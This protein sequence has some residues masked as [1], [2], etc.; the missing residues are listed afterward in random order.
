MNRALSFFKRWEFVLFILLAVELLGFGAASPNFLNL[1]NL[2]YSTNDFAQILFIA[3]P[4]TLVVITGGIDISVGSTMGLASICFGIMWKFMGCPIWVALVVTLAIG[5]MAGLLNGL[6]VAYTDINPIVLTLGTMFLYQGLATGFSGSIGAS[7]YNGIGGFPESFTNLSY[8]TVLGVPDALLFALIFALAIAALLNRTALGRS[9]FLIG[10]NRK[11]AIYSGIRVRRTTI[12]AFVLTGIGAAIAGLFLT[13]YFTSSRS[14]LGKDAL[15]PALTAVVLGGTD[16][17]GGAG[18]ILGTFVAAIFLGY[19]KQGL[20]ALGVTSD[21][22]QVTVGFILIATVVIKEVT[23]FSAQRR[24]NRSALKKI[25]LPEA[26]VP[27]S[28]V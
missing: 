5:A 20:M 19:M 15:M 13:A 17:N 25:A 12:T 6:L 27:S 8:G 23:A 22:S 26:N 9:Y 1:G 2:L 16:I 10:V 28:T 24:L 18:S 4:F 21:V 11:A 14:D 7:G 3:I